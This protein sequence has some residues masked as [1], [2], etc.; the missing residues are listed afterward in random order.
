MM[1]RNAYRYSYENGN[2]TDDYGNKH[3]L[4]LIMQNLDITTIFRTTSL[5]ISIAV[6]ASKSLSLSLFPV[7]SD[8]RFD[9][10]IVDT[11]ISVIA[12]IITVVFI[13]AL[14]IAAV[15][16]IIVIRII[17]IVMAILAFSHYYFFILNYYHH[18]RYQR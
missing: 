6:C 12:M 18:Y 8:S 10:I 17:I 11:D 1:V 3:K 7:M 14:V 2:I 9:V 4:V 13:D 5:S 15:G 16:V